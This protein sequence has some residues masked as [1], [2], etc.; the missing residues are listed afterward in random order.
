MREFL[1]ST[2]VPAFESARRPFPAE[3]NRTGRTR[4]RSRRRR[5]ECG[6]PPR[7]RPACNGWTTTSGSISTSGSIQVVAGS[8]I[9]TPASMCARLMR[10]RRTAAAS[11][12]S[13][14]VLTPRPRT[15]RRRAG[16]RRSRRRRR[17]GR[18]CRSGRARPGRCAPRSARASARAVRAGRRRSRVRLADRELLRRRVA[19][20]DD[21]REPAV[22]RRARAGRS[23]RAS[24]YSMPSTVAAAPVARCVVDERRGAS[25]AVSS[26]HV[27]GE[28]E[29]VAVGALERGPRARGRR[30][31]CRAA[32]PARRP[33]RPRS[34]RSS[35]ARRRRRSG[36]RRRRARR[37]SPSRP[38]G[39]RAA[40][41]GASARPTHARAEAGGHDDGC[42]RGVAHVSGI[43]GWGARI[44]TWD[45]G[46][47]TRCLTAW[48]RP[49]GARV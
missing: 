34:R 32:A 43:D 9:V 47:K 3:G 14:R 5:H 33:R 48:L 36:R 15:A 30:R 4:F 45:R 49:T 38:C 27:A 25:P 46:T 29:H 2:K 24:S 31:R 11:A 1:I 17:G 35:A 8:T 41:A 19:R 16:R 10:S 40:G 44:R 39:G 13:A 26:R 12:S 42:D 23:A 6:S 18:S 37:R 7:M 21:P 22:A 20:L 28:D